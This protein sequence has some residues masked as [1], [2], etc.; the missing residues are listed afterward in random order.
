MRNLVNAYRYSE[1]ILKFKL[2]NIQI[3]LELRILYALSFGAYT[4]KVMA[5]NTVIT[6]GRFGILMRVIAKDDSKLSVLFA[7]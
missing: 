2:I 7:Q 5:A 6:C 4:F 3:Y 1:I